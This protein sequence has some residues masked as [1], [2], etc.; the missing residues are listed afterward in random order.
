VADRLAGDLHAV[1]AELETF[2]SVRQPALH[3]RLRPGLRERE[4]EVVAR[5]L[6]PYYIPAE[7]V[8]L[9][10]WHD[11]WQI[12]L[13]DE[14]QILL[15]SAPFN[16]LADS[17]A[18]YASWLA[19]LGSDGWHPLWF[20]AFGDK[21]GELVILQLEPNQPAGPLYTFD[22][23]AVDL[24]SSYDSVSTLFF[25]VL[26]GCRAGVLP[27]TPGSPPHQIREIV[28]R[29]NPLSRTPDG[30][31]R[32]S[33]ARLSTA[34]WPSR[35]REAVGLPA[36]APLP[37]APVSTIVDLIAGSGAGRPIR[38]ELRGWGGSPD[39][40]IATAIDHTGSLVVFLDRSATQNFREFV[41]GHVF[42]AWLVPLVDRRRFDELAARMRRI[43]DP[44]DVPYLATRIVPLRN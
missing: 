44:P 39:H 14:Y 13:D 28:A 35:W 16:S 10:R 32:S 4:L 17:I 8:A 7:L 30:V 6:E 42:E 38:A 27:H 40:V 24:C 23:D 29:C 21:A 25:T 1:L 31:S 15:P 34:G 11:G 36:V 5:S 20:P 26:E 33:V 43:A 3:A 22:S 41:G 2:T 9:Y 37:D 19:A 12:F 18:Q